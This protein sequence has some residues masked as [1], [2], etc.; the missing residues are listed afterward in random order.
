M[1]AIEVKNLSKSYDNIKVV[2]NIS[3][4]VE[5]GTVFGF[6]GPNGAGKTTTLEMIEGLRK[7]DSGEIFIDGLDVSKDLK[8]IQSIIGVQLQSVT[9]DERMR[10][11][12]ALELFA[13]FYPS[14]ANI[15]YLLELANLTDRANQFQKDLSGG[16]KQ[17]LNMALCLVNDP[18]IVFLDEP[19]TGLDPQARRNLWDIII[20]LKE[21]GKTVILTTHYMDEAEKLCDFISIIDHGSIIKE[22]T[23]DELIAGLGAGRIIELPCEEAQQA[24]IKKIKTANKIEFQSGFAEIQ[25]D[26]LT[27]TLKEI[28]QLDSSFD[29][30]TLHIRKAT[31]EDVFIDL[32]GRSLRE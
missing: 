15:D 31:L 25:T 2:N 11:R 14:S 21:M 13:T 29:V 6:L 27:D 10:V 26:Q 32:T 28:L 19:T 22:G 1:A 4:S 17:R 18:K 12:E 9:L 30:D 7:V 16:Q 20:K 5:A 24:E 8:K 3:F 23:P